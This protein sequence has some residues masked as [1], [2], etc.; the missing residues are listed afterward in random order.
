MM[1]TATEPY[2]RSH[3]QSPVL[4]LNQNYEP[5]NVC[6]IRRAVVLVICEKAEIIEAY[7]AP[8]YTTTYT[9]EAP[10]IIRLHQLIKRP[11]PR[12]K[13]TR[14]EV[15]VRDRYTCQYCGAVHND[16]TLDHVIPRSKGGAH[17][18]ENLV[19]A[20]RSCNHRKGGKLVNEARMKLMQTPFEPRAGAYYAIERRLQTSAVDSWLKFLPGLDA[21]SYNLSSSSD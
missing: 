7:G 1:A 11:R 13:L 21:S 9:F 6:T 2:Q 18:W 17:T 8:L 5:I 16:L 12:V 19:T 3:T 4:V 14:R 15:F 10:S 20:C